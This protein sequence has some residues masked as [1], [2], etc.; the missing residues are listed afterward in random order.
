MEYENYRKQIIKLISVK[1]DPL[2]VE[3][4]GEISFNDPDIINL[5][6]EMKTR[7]FFGTIVVYPLNDGTYRIESGHRRYYA[8]VLAGFNELP[9]SVSDPPVTDLDRR[10][11]LDRW[12]DHIRTNNPL[13][14]ARR[15]Q[16]KF[17]TYEAINKE[18]KAKGL[19]TYPILDRVAKELDVSVS[20]VTK[21]KMLLNL[22]PEL[23][24]LISSGNYNWA[25]MATASQLTPPQQRL[26]YD[27]IIRESKLFT[28]S[29]ITGA[30]INREVDQIKR[31][32]LSDDVKH[33]YEYDRNDLSFLS[34]ELKERL[35]SN[36]ANQETGKERRFRR[37]DGYKR[38][39]QSKRYLD[40]L[41][42]NDILV[43]DNEK[44]LL[45]KNLIEMQKTIYNILQD[46]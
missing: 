40:S 23:Q 24:N 37:K 29:H 19:P 34:D 26:L 30:W 10:Q 18:N 12:N 44:E 31:I 9:F 21:Y 13:L 15:A 2:N 22:I 5:S 14:F 6:E 38:I 28:E 4:Y 16:F 33:E 42:E 43:K 25:A 36:E 39:L 1:P 3:A 20:N 46:L 11:R 45:K 35:L 27:K 32:I 8:A 7:G 41:L 17:K